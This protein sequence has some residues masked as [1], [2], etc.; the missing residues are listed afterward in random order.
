MTFRLL[1]AVVLGLGTI[2]LSFAADEV[3]AIK[4]KLVGKW[5]FTRDSKPGKGQKQL[6]VEFTKDGDYLF[7]ND[8]PKAP[9]LKGTYK[10]IDK[11]TVEIALNKAKPITVKFLLKEDKLWF[12][13]TLGLNRKEVPKDDPRTEMTKVTSTPKMKNE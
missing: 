8:L 10:L 7:Q 6:T 13:P 11:E 2:P 5:H 9:L 4:E 12:D 3:D 1:V